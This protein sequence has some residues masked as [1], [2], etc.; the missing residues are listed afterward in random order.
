VFFLVR[1]ETQSNYAAFLAVLLAAFG[2]YMPAHAVDWGKYPA[3]TSLSLIAFVASLAYLFF[4]Y[5]KILSI[6]NNLGLMVILVLAIIVSGLMHSRALIV[7]GSLFLAW[8]I[9]SLWQRLPRLPQWIF[10][11]VILAG[12]VAEVF[13]IRTKDVFGPLFDPY[14][15]KGLLISGIV[16]VLAIFA[17][18]KYP[19]LTFTLIVAI[20]LLLGSLFIPI[21]GITGYADLT[22]LDRPFVEM[23]LFLPLSLLGGLGWA[24]LSQELRERSVRLRN[25]HL[26]WSQMM[27]S[28]LLAVIL[29]NAL[30]NYEVYP[31]SCCSI[32][33]ND[34]LVALDWM[35]KNLPADAHVLISSTQLM[36]MATEAFQGAVGSDAGIWVQPLTGRT[37]F[38]MPY[39]SDFSQPAM[40]EA[41][42]KSGVTHIYVGEQGLTFDDSTIA[43][44]MDWYK[45]LL[46]MPKVKIYEVIGCK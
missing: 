9:A 25:V 45:A 27:G 42:C 14:I 11:V 28:I 31:S 16:L 18:W 37:M 10:L 6:R 40:L 34:D 44:Y 20:C 21:R 29:I 4:Q 33:S 3:L 24:G 15:N 38:A 19:R 13:W 32:V 30:F 5:R 12:I 22:L 39:T 43:P 36:F 46:S 2:W 17:Q 7:E 41:L 26:T 23:V 8:I 35:D 1:H